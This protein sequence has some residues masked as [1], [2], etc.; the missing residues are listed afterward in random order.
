MSLPLGIAALTRVS[1]YGTKLENQKKTIE[2]RSRSKQRLVRR[3][4]LFR[5]NPSSLQLAAEVS[6]RK[7]QDPCLMN[8]MNVSNFFGGWKFPLLKL[9]KHRL[10]GESPRWHP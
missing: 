7:S 1:Y 8:R 6:E 5:F 4:S 3:G 9:H 2:S 10:P